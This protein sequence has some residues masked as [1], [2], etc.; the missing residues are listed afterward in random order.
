ME[1]PL[2]KTKATEREHLALTGAGR[3]STSIFRLARSA[4][5]PLPVPPPPPAAT[6]FVGA[7]S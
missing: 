5:Y 4:S 3:N 2:L 1:F 7:G 6:D